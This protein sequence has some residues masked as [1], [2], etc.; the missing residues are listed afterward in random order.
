MEK[1]NAF[2][3]YLFDTNPGSDFSYY[4]PILILS[5]LLIAAGIA[6][7]FVYNNRK[8]YDFAFK[9]MFKN[10]SKTLVLFGILFMFLLGTR[11]ENIPYFGMR[12]VLYISLLGL[13]Y[14]LF[15]YIKTHRI[16]YKK[17]ITLNPKSTL[18]KE[19]KKETSY[20]AKK[21]RK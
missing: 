16:D 7:M 4:L 15:R 1:V 13:A 10:T 17:E 21:R 5:G 6:F 3:R 9:K 20:S 2:F 11:Y 18:K 14:V 12:F 19:V 8:K